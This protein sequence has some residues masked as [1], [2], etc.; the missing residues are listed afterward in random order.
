MHVH[1]VFVTK[2]RQDV[3]SEL[4]IGDLTQMFI[5][6]TRPVLKVGRVDRV[7]D[8]LLGVEIGE[9][10]IVG[11]RGKIFQSG[12]QIEAGWRVHSIDLHQFLSLQT[13]YA[14]PASGLRTGGGGIYAFP[15]GRLLARQAPIL[16]TSRCGTSFATP[17]N[18][19]EAI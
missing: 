17:S 10:H 12:C 11:Q 1:L 4:A 2:Y 16:P 14:A 18:R 15:D 9:T 6:V 7:V 13:G 8:M 5:S 3:L 19:K